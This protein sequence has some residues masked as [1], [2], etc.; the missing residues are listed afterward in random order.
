MNFMDDFIVNKIERT[1]LKKKKR[2][3]LH[4][5]ITVQLPK[6][7]KCLS[8]LEELSISDIEIEPTVIVPED[9][10][11]RFIAR[12]KGQLKPINGYQLG[13]IVY[14]K[15]LLKLKISGVL[16]R[17]ISPLRKLRK[18]ESIELHSTVLRD[19]A[20]LKGL[21]RLRKLNLASTRVSDITPITNLR[22]L[23]YL[24]LSETDVSDLSAI[25]SLTKL[26]AL[27]LSAS[28]TIDI[29][30]L[31]NLTQLEILNLS[32]CKINDISPI[33]TLR[34]LTT[35]SLHYLRVTSLEF[36]RD[37]HLVA[38][39]DIRTTLVRSL[40][41]ISNLPLLSTLR[42]SNCAITDLSPLSA[43][44]SL[45][46]LDL[47][48]TLVREFSPLSQINSLEHLDAEGTMISD[49]SIND[50]PRRL[51]KLSLKKTKIKNISALSNL[52]CLE[53]INLS[54]T[55]ITD[56]S[57]LS[58]LSNLRK[59]DITSTKVVDLRPIELLIRKGLAI[60]IKGCFLVNPP[61][62]I[63]HAGTSAILSFW[64]EIALAGQSSQKE[65]KL[66][67]V[68]NATAG[69]SS[70]AHALSM[71]VFTPGIL[72]TVGGNLG[73]QWFPSKTNYTVNIWDFGGQE[74]FHATYRMLMNDEAI[75]MVV[76]DPLFDS[77]RLQLTPI[78]YFDKSEVIEEY[79][80]HFH[81][82]YWLETIT[83]MAPRSKILFVWTKMGDEKR[84]SAYEKL[85]QAD[86]IPGGILQYHNDLHKTFFESKDP[87][88]ENWNSLKAN[89]VAEVHGKLEGQVIVKYWPI[90]REA[91]K[92]L[93]K[94]TLRISLSEFNAICNTS[95][96]SR[97]IGNIV[98]YLRD[99]CGAILLFEDH[100]VLKDVVFINT[101]KLNELIY[102][103]LNHKVKLAGGRFSHSE[104]EEQVLAALAEISD[105]GVA[106]DEAARFTNHI[107][108]V[109]KLL[110]VIFEITPGS[111]EYVAP[112]YLPREVPELLK[113]EKRRAKLDPAFWIRFKTYI[114]R[115][116]IPRYIALK[117]I[118]AKQE[119]WWKF[120][121]LYEEGPTATALVQVD[122]SSRVLAISIHD[123][124][125]HQAELNAIFQLLKLLIENDKALEVSLDGEVWVD[126]ERLK[127]A[128]ET[129]APLA[130][131]VDGHRVSVERFRMF[132]SNK[133]AKDQYIFAESKNYDSMKH[134]YISYAKEDLAY[135]KDLE[136]CLEIFRQ[137]GEFSS[138]SRKHILPGDRTLEVIETE[139]SKADV[140]IMLVSADYIS[141]KE[142][143]EARFEY[144]KVVKLG[145]AG[146]CLIIPVL[147]K[148]YHRWDKLPI[149]IYPAAL[150][151][152]PLDQEPNK[153][154]AWSEIME[155][156][157]KILETRE[158]IVERS[159]ELGSDRESRDLLIKIAS[160]VDQILV[161]Q[162]RMEGNITVLL[163]LTKENLT[164]IKTVQEFVDGG[165][166]SED[167]MVE[168][169]QVIESL[170]T[171]H[172]NDLGAEVKAEIAKLK[173]ADFDVKKRLKWTIPLI[174]FVLRYE[175]DWNDNSKTKKG[176]SL[177]D[178]LR[179]GKLTL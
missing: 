18:L 148:S 142:N 121:I 17:D 124:K 25:L 119:T 112:Q 91:I 104:A 118:D 129:M 65:I 33:S 164:E 141:A 16:L 71:G 27:N 156:I 83:A 87:W 116:I 99:M 88:I 177:W 22:E 174:P 5:M 24:N 67:L 30:S 146:K 35:I 136:K 42:L 74:Y 31:T 72:S 170:I 81:H 23:L 125:R 149:G 89:L 10:I 45:S 115:H 159:P 168:A 70:I 103:I 13:N 171:V 56:L 75:Y 36:I 173:A 120:G 85:C 126:F 133:L 90:V 58:G 21:C 73:I 80:E 158:K 97:D 40:E 41:P 131:T 4:G 109:M 132:S 43:L 52:S 134:I 172:I 123:P 154:Q 60:E 144:E 69:K 19:I 166:F 110:E 106:V 160:G 140:V 167:Q 57:P 26:V 55:N 29:S 178:D 176:W 113:K 145:Y 114:P 169:I 2:L 150:G 3:E 108:E 138:W 39:L 48:Y 94:K 38:Y 77:N 100:A 47:S 61:I 84:A 68:G 20:P 153:D 51:K 105:T 8:F 34:N 128:M 59:I 96:G 37:L 7:I 147:L 63:A 161:S 11:L 82:N 28:K 32:K 64:D 127:E 107:I 101:H 152:R 46:F 130:R 50:L 66:F 15:N 139:L 175:M 165:A 143:D 76:C 92:E 14:L 1:F 54:Y 155:W 157:E 6:E 102:A 49:L 111:C 137:T 135:L 86:P 98:I 78:R 53:E 163:D 95:G 117:G 151:G 162:V 122:Y 12:L 93:S 79:L 9:P 62:E 179:K 44:K